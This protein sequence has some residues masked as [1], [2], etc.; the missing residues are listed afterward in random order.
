MNDPSVKY[1]YDIGKNN[2]LFFCNTW[3][4]SNNFAW[5]N[6]NKK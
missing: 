6:S 4:D 1:G 5:Y 2:I 3:W